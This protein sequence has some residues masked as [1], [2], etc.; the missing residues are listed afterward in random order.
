MMLRQHEFVKRLDRKY[1]SPPQ[2]PKRN[3]LQ[4]IV[5][6]KDIWGVFMIFGMF[7]GISILVFLCEIIVGRRNN[8]NRQ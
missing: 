3:E 1:F 2:Q 6:F 7:V 5:T 4:S 8:I